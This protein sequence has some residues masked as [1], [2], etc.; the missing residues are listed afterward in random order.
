MKRSH[1][2]TIAVLSFLAIIFSCP[3]ILL[4]KDNPALAGICTAIDPSNPC[5]KVQ[6][7]GYAAI[8]GFDNAYIGIAA[9]FVLFTLALMQAFKPDKILRALVIAGSIIAG[10]AGLAFMIIQAFVI[11]AFCLYCTIVDGLAI[12][13]MIVGLLAVKI[14]LKQSK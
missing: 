11:K 9:F 13:M 5:L 3:I 4:H 8:L 1:A 2:I 14:S 10:L 7:S 12:A 6:E